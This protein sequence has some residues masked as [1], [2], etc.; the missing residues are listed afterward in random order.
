MCLEGADALT[1][2]QIPH[3]DLK[4]EQIRETV[5]ST[6]QDKQQGGER[7]RIHRRVFTSPSQEPDI[8]VARLVLCLAMQFT[9]SLCPSRAP[10]KGLANTRSS[11]VAFR[12]RVYS[13]FT[14]KG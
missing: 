11:L 2:G 10:R 14:S 4:V 12:A 1:L 8:R 3:F 6:D 13:L 7:G 9:P 5:S